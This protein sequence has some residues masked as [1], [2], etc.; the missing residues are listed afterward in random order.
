MAYLG[1]RG[2]GVAWFLNIKLSSNFNIKFDPPHWFQLPN[3]ITAVFTK[4]IF[5]ICIDYH[6]S[7]LTQTTQWDDPRKS[8]STNS[9]NTLQQHHSSPQLSPNVSLQNLGPLPQGWE[10]AS[11]PAGEVYFINHNNRTTSWFD[12]RLRKYYSGRMID[13]DGD[14]GPIFRFDQKCSTMN[15]QCQD[16][17]DCSMN[18]FSMKEEVISRN[19]AI[20][21]YMLYSGDFFSTYSETFTKASHENQWTDTTE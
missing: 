7:H 2:G 17:L 3:S 4:F 21:T 16:R 14:Q 18:I 8:L 15:T 13:Q 10:Q 9:L 6:F 1:F 20:H 11:T 12:P 5:K 19:T